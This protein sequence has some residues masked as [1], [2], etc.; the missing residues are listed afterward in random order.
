[1]QLLSYQSKTGLVMG[2]AVG[3]LYDCGGL[4]D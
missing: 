1:M 2:R 3:A 4:S